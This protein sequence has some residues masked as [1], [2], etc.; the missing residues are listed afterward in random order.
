[1]GCSSNEKGAIKIR[2]VGNYQIR[3]L[4]ISQSFVCL[5]KRGKESNVIDLVK[6][7]ALMRFLEIASTVGFVAIILLAISFGRRL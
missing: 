1:M 5:R 2:D 7:D 3:K 6:A 4:K